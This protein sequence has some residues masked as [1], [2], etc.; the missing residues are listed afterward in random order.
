MP[1]NR[2]ALPWMRI[3]AAL[4]VGAVGILFWRFS[5]R[6]VPSFSFPALNDAAFIVLVWAVPISVLGLAG[7][8][9]HR[10]VSLAL[11]LIGLPLVFVALPLSFLSALMMFDTLTMGKDASFEQI[12]ELKGRRSTFRAYRSDGGA[13]TSY[14]VVLRREFDVVPGFRLVSF[15]CSLQRAYQAQLIFLSD[16][17]GRLTSSCQRCVERTCDFDL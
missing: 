15:E 13:T 9:P 6:I 16:R 10:W 8:V 17:R 4:L 12:A 3:W 14:S 1:G 2:R 7:T 11:L 5:S